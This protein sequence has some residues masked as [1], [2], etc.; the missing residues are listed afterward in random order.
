M[1]RR[2]FEFLT[3]QIWKMRFSELPR[4]QRVL[5]RPLRV[6]VLAL[7]GFNEDRIQIRASALTYYTLL[8]VVPVLAV[9]FGIAK[10]FGLQEALERQLL[11]YSQG[12]EEV[13]RQT[14]DFANTAILQ[15][16]GGVVAGAGIVLLL[17]AAIRLLGSIEVSLNEIWGVTKGRSLGRRFFDYLTIVL[18]APILLTT[19]GALTASVAGVVSRLT[20]RVGVL[21]SMGVVDTLVGGFVP[22]VMVVLFF[23]LIYRLIPNTSVSLRASTLAALLAGA[24]YQVAQWAYL[25]FQVKMTS[26][27]AVYGTFAAL[28]LFLIW[29]QLSWLVILFGAE[30]SF[31]IDN[32]EKYAL[33]RQSLHVT[34]R[35]RRVLALR[36]TQI[37]ARRFALGEDPLT[38]IDLAN[39][40]EIPVRL[41]R[42]ILHELIDAKVLVEVAASGP[43][44]ARLQPARAISSLTVRSVLE[45]LEQCGGRLL[46]PKADADTGVI[47]EVLA[48]FDELVTRSPK[49]VPLH[50]LPQGVT[51]T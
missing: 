3:D 50:Q 6:L 30:V 20:S 37:I 13:I 28:P 15:A 48:H 21:G 36:L 11:F 8:S 17:W 5:L 23:A 18:I 14:I 41:A 12:Q 34:Q 42:D 25:S 7:R 16:R 1:I 47:R 29:L 32:E 4:R 43:E 22:F 9:A 2:A 24:L 46:P 45:A 39:E 51:Q 27:N 38:I 35:L 26:Y 10:G 33:E 31:A 40:L 49:N 44:V 19:S